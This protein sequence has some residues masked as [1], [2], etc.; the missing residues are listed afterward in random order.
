MLPVLLGCGLRRAEVTALG[1]RDLL[2]TSGVPG[3]LVLFIS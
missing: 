3:M 2:K 1:V